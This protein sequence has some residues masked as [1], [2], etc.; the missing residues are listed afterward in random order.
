MN[1]NDIEQVEY[2][3]DINQYVKDITTL[4]AENK[5]GDALSML[6]IFYQKMGNTDKLNSAIQ[7]LSRYNDLRQKVAIGVINTSDEMIEKNKINNS[8]IT[9]L[10][11]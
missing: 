10:T 5:T 1:L 8:I 11:S 7:I 6:I 2:N 4:I 9:L 3:L